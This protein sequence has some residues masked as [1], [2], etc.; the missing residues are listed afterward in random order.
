MST[1]SGCFLIADRIA[2]WAKWGAFTSNTSLS[3]KTKY[4]NIRL[5]TKKNNNQKYKVH[6]VKIKNCRRRFTTIKRTQKAKRKQSKKRKQKEK[7][8]E[9]KTEGKQKGRIQKRKRKRKK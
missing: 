4:K 9:R 6:N 8:K 3:S 7:R 5:H 2:S 1:C